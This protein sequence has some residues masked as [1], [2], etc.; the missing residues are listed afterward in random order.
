MGYNMIMTMQAIRFSGGAVVLRYFNVYSGMWIWFYELW[1]GKMRLVSC[2]YTLKS[3]T[4]D[5]D[6]T[7]SCYRLEVKRLS[8]FT[9]EKL[10]GNKSFWVEI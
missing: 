8:A 10:L 2:K 5:N 6:I 4:P 7:F 3:N 9:Y 1:H